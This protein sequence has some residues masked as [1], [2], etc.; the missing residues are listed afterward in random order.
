MAQKPGSV[1][2]PLLFTQVKVVDSHGEPCSPNQYGD[3]LVSGLNVMQGY[4]N[5]PQA[6]ADRFSDG[7][8]HTGDIGYLDEDGDLWLVQ[9]RSDL[10]VSGGENIYP[11]EVEAVLRLHPA[12]KEACVVGLPDPEWGQQVA[13]MIEPIP[14]YEPSLSINQLLEHTLHHLARYKQ[15]RLIEIVDQLPQTAS[16]KIA[17]KQVANQ[18]VA[19]ISTPNKTGAG[20]TSS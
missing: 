12:V 15:P 16:G 9:R 8:F 1:G 20:Q 7:Y 6:N 5:N 14:D 13:A 3:I 11:A 19:Q 17:R 10:I 4:L 2:H 18:L